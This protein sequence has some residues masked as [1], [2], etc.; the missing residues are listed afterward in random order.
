MNRFVLHGHRNY[1]GKH[2]LINLV[3]APNPRRRIHHIHHSYLHCFQYFASPIYSPE[4]ES[5]SVI[6]PKANGKILLSE[7]ISVFD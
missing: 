6:A 4:N 5:D 7:K 3:H 2:E 1:L